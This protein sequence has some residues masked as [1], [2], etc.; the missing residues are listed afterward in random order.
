MPTKEVY[1]EQKNVSDIQECQPAKPGSFPGPECSKE[2]PLLKKHLSELIPLKEEKELIPRFVIHAH[3][4][5]RKGTT[6]IPPHMS[7]RTWV[8]WFSFI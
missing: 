4:S 3:G 8:A 7:I 5:V 1:L 2:S 6:S